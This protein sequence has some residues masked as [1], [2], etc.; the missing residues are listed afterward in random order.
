MGGNT[1]EWEDYEGS[2]LGLVSAGQ[3]TREMN[4]MVNRR[5]SEK[6]KEDHP[7][8]CEHVVHFLLGAGAMAVILCLVILMACC[9]YRLARGH[10]SRGA[11]DKLAHDC[12]V[13]GTV[14]LLKQICWLPLTF[15][16]CY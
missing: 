15:P 9:L 12:G 2:G 16:P 5:L 10:H 8:L 7:E 1:P 14:H 6:S 11:G 3:M 13:Q 4:L